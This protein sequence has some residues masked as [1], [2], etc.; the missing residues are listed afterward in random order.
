MNFEQQN[1]TI[2]NKG[3]YMFKD[4]KD[5][6]RYYAKLY[7][8]LEIEP[9]DMF[10]YGEAEAKKANAEITRIQKQMGYEH[11]NDDFYTYLKS[12]KFY[13]TKTNKIEKKFREKEKAIRNNLYKLFEN[14]TVP[15]FDIIAS[16]NTDPMMSPGIYINGQTRF[17]YNFREG[18]QNVRAM[19]FLIIHE[20][21]PGHHYQYSLQLKDR[22]N[23]PAFAQNV[24]YSGNFEGWA[25]YT[26]NLG[27]E[28]GQYQTPEE[29]L[30]KWE[31]D[32]VRSIRLMLDVGINYYGWSMEKA[33]AFWNENIKGQDDIAYREITRVIYWPGQSLSYKIGAMKIEEFKSRLHVTDTTIKRFHSVFLSFSAE[34]LE[35]IERNIGEVYNAR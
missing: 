32:L 30:S 23:K 19:G 7:T 35:V 21:I 31:W 27:K 11:R 29:E 25:S 1:E 28:L 26:E 4:H 13:L 5:W 14:I 33:I 18:R 3:L 6:Y 16:Q 2:P 10:K 22:I 15:N 24:S 20:G 17:V 34:P 12:E 9:D 8:S